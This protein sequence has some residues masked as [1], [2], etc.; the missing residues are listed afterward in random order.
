M[1]QIIL[2]VYLVGC[3]VT[4]VYAAFLLQKMCVKKFQTYFTIKQ[5]LKSIFED[6]DLVFL[7]SWYGLYILLKK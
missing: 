2:L 5:C 1:I 4:M 7:K 3:L 6:P